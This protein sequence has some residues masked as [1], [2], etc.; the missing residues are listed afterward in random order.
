MIGHSTS[1]LLCMPSTVWHHDFRRLLRKHQD[2]K[3]LT[4][5][6]VNKHTQQ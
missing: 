5:V 1:L 4:I 6:Y 2:R 3:L